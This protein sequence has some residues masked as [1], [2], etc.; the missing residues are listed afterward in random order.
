VPRDAISQLERQLN[1]AADR[2]REAGDS[3]WA[4]QDTE[5]SP[6]VAKLRESVSRLEEKLAK[7]QASGRTK[8][9][10]KVE[11]DLATQR[12]WLAQAQ[13]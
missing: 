11:A 5:T 2:I 9:I 12:A 1:A 8:D 3:R 7:A 10:A 4:R 13:K 6:F